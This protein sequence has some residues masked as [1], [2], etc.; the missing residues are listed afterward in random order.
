M[1]ERIDF[2]SKVLEGAPRVNLSRRAIIS[3]IAAGTVFP[4]VSG[5]TTNPHTGASQLLLFGDDQVASMAATAWTDM[6]AQTP[7]TANSRLK[8][9]VL[10]VWE[11]TV[12]GA[13]ARGHV[14][15]NAS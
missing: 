7:V 15:P 12:D 4:F 13:A 5:C 11:R 6:K 2:D 10:G 3:G 9:R 1:V 8:N 14:D